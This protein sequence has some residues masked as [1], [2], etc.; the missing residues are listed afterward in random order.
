MS[1]LGQPPS[2]AEGLSKDTLEKDIEGAET[3]KVFAENVAWLVSK[4]KGTG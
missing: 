4:L 3:L 1:I 2:E